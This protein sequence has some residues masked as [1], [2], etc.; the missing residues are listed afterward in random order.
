MIYE[1]MLVRLILQQYFYLKIVLI[2]VVIVTI[3][4]SNGGGAMYMHT[5]DICMSS[6]YLHRK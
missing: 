4:I 3:L 1:N 6:I 5:Y 2:V